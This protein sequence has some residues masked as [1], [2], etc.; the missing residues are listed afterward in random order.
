[1]VRVVHDNRTMRTNQ[2]FRFVAIVGL[3]VALLTAG[4]SLAG[5]ASDTPEDPETTT[6]EPIDDVIVDDGDVVDG[7]TVDDGEVVDGDG[8]VDDDGALV[9][10]DEGEVDGDDLTDTEDE[11]DEPTAT[12]DEGDE[13]GDTGDEGDTEECDDDEAAVEDD[14]AETESDDVQVA[15]EPSEAHVG[16]CIAAV[17]ASDVDLEL[18]PAVGPVPGEKHGLENA[19]GR[20]F[21]NCVHHENRGLP[22]ALDHL[23]HNLNE[24]LKRE[25]LR[26]EAR[27][28]RE[29]AKAEREAARDEA[30]AARDAAHAA[31]KAARD[32]AKAARTAAHAS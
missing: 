3:V 25:D 30:K 21:W 10:G 20:V 13:P 26:E 1:M 19:I 15:A 9:D 17:D 12:E 22:N 23:V 11:G 18:D 32:A 31:A 5:G 14:A 16:A 28:E 6:C 24:K 4:I 2:R 27:A 29:V 7:E 8:S